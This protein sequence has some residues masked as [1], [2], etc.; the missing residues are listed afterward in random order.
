MKIEAI[1]FYA[2]YNGN[3]SLLKAVKAI[4]EAI[5]LY[6][7]CVIPSFEEVLT[8]QAH[9]VWNKSYPD[10]GGE[11]M[12]NI[13]HPMGQ[14]KET[15]LYLGRDKQEFL[16]TFT[17]SDPSVWIWEAVRQYVTKIPCKV[18]MRN[19]GRFYFNHHLTELYTGPTWDWLCNEIRKQSY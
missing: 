7:G 8:G 1:S 3:E 16:S 10:G 11:T 13:H 2:R 9:N 4:Y 18:Y 14:E 17:I 5:K 12:I 19:G 15:I 6:H